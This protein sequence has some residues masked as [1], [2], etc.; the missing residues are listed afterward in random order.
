MKLEYDKN[1]DCVYILINDVKHHHTHELD[2]I[3]FIDY[4]ENG[5]V[6]GIE[7]LFVESGVDLN[8]L[9]YQAEIKE[10]LEKNSIKTFL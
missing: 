6:Q 7:F 5:V 2:E 8:D 1:A 3:R 4:G 10:L 9:P